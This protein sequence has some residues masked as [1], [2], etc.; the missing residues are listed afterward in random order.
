MILGFKQQFVAPILAGTK[1]HTLRLDPNDRWVPYM[2]IHFAT[3]VRT[4]NYKCFKK[5]YCECV[6]RVLISHDG[7]GIVWV[8]VDGY[9]LPR[10]TKTL[11]IKND[12]FENEKDF[13]DW[14]FPKGKKNNLF[15]KLIHWTDFKY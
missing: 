15:L 9:A 13:I 1:I 6:Q 10:E 12:G 5:G 8:V 3:G 2:P 11:F 4:Q 14:F 7:D